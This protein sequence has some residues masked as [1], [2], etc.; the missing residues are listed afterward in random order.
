MSEWIKKKFY[1]HNLEFSGVSYCVSLFLFLI[2]ALFVLGE[3]F[4]NVKLAF[5]HLLRLDYLSPLVGMLTNTN[6]KRD[7]RQR[8][9]VHFDKPS[10]KKIINM[11]VPSVVFERFA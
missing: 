7:T 5:W 2:Y 11:Y 3:S 1:V 4:R 9:D 6:A 10:R 8:Y